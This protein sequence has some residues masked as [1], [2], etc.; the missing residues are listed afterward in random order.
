MARFQ[1]IIN[2]CFNSPPSPHVKYIVIIYGSESITSDLLSVLQ[3]AADLYRG[4]HYPVVNNNGRSFR[5]AGFKS[6]YRGSLSS[7]KRCTDSQHIG[8]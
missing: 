5:I 4:T 3:L 6:I 7:Q 8:S 2:L 1:R